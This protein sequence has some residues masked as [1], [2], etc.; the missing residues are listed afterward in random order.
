[1]KTKKKYDIVV[2]FATGVGEPKFKIYNKSQLP[3]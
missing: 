1:M 2:G 3:G